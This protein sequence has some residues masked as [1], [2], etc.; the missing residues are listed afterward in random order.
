MTDIFE[1]TVRILTEVP[2]ERSIDLGHLIIQECSG[3]CFDPTRYL[4]E[5]FQFLDIFENS[6]GRVASIA[7]K[8]L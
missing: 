2:I 7:A 6:I 8:G 3:A 1:S 4:E 5:N